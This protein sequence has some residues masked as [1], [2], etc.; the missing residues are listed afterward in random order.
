MPPSITLPCL[1]FIGVPPGDRCTFVDFSREL[2][3][4]LSASTIEVGVAVARADEQRRA[5]IWAE[6]DSTCLWE[7]CEVGGGGGDAA[8][9]RGAYL[10]F[11]SVSKFDED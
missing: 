3:P 1:L 7:A 5:G 11:S 6:G 9:E 8:G 10:D 4:I 2:L